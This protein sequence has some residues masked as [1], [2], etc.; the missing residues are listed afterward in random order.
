MAILTAFSEA[1]GAA[2]LLDISRAHIDGCLYHGEVS[3][4]FVERLVAGS[5][6]QTVEFPPSPPRT[7]GSPSAKRGREPKIDQGRYGFSYS[8]PQFE[9]GLRHHNS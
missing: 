6:G 7:A 4:D 8:C 5:L 2:A 9:S 1:I 3:L